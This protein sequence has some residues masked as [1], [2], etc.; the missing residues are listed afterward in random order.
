MN[1]DAQ[2]KHTRSKPAGSERGQGRNR[3]LSQGF[4]ARSG[5]TKIAG[6][7]NRSV[8]E[9]AARELESLALNLARKDTVQK[10]TL[11][12][13]LGLSDKGVPVRLPALIVPGLNILRELRNVANADPYYVIYQARDFITRVNRLDATQAFTNAAQ[14]TQLVSDF[15]NEFYPDLKDRVIVVPGEKADIE[16]DHLAGLAGQ[17]SKAR[18]LDMYEDMKT[19]YGYAARRNTQ[20]DGH[21]Y[22]AAANV[23]LNGG[24]AP[25]YPLAGIVPQ[26]TSV[27]MPIGGK[28]E[29]PFFNLTRAVSEQT[30]TLHTIMP[31]IVPVG[32][33]PA[34]YPNRRGDLLVGE[35][36][37]AGGF[38][39]P[40]EIE[41]D[42][43]LLEHSGI[44]VERL[45]T[46]AGKVRE[47]THG[48]SY[49]GYPGRNGPTGQL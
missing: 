1:N 42:F 3:I 7:K 2:G 4:L 17:L 10:I 49:A 5:D 44:P 6:M 18:S 34:Y 40:P 47:Q 33:I 41:G 36:R 20:Q 32:K 12:T 23:I 8:S 24:Y 39:P 28:K 31:L 22:Y 29:K 25:H 43:K 16:E 9:E 37:D 35:G 19:I 38:D 46:L 13:G 26:D 45:E 21:L 14:C 27:I 48:K 30:G 15:I 11:T